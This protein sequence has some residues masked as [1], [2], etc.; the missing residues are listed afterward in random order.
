MSLVLKYI[1]FWL[2]ILLSI[3]FYRL[4]LDNHFYEVLSNILLAF[5]FIFTSHFFLNKILSVVVWIISVVVFNVCVFIQ[6]AHY[7][8]FQDNIKSS[9]LFIVFDTDSSEANDF[10]SMYAD[11]SLVVTA[12]ILLITI[13]I[14]IA[15]VYQELKSTKNTPKRY[16]IFNLK[17]NFRF[18]YL[19][20]ILIIGLVLVN[21]IRAASLP[22]TAFK[23]YNKYT[24]ENKK[25]NDVAVNKLGGKFTNVTHKSSNNSEV[26]VLI[27]GEST[28]RNHMQLYG[29]NRKTTPKLNSIKNSLLV[30]N[31]VITPHTHTIKSLEKVLTLAN[32]RNPE[33]KFDGS[34]IQLFNK[35]GFNTYW[36]SNQTPLGINETAT[37]VL[38]K[39]CTERYFLNTTV[40]E[41][42]YDEKVLKP[43]DLVLSKKSEKK[44][45]VI[46]LLGTHGNYINR[47]PSIYSTFNGKPE[48]NFKHDKAFA[49]I[50][51]YDNAVLYNDF[52]VT[53]IIKKV[54]NRNSKSFA[55]YFSDHGEDVYN[56]MDMACHT[57]SKGSK[58]M[59]D[60][61]FILWQSEIYKKENTDL[62][63]NVN[64][65]WSTEDL[66][67][68]LSDLA[69]IKFNQFDASRSL[70]NSKFEQKE[71]L[72]FNN[73]TYNETF[74]IQ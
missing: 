68:T 33:K 32:S 51:A 53:E 46:H 74:K 10:F 57:E 18:N 66:I 50:N 56:T 38:S 58:P 31:N 27:I 15:V 65:P 28:T 12:V 40:D 20:F 59:Y 16:S 21:N 73:K 8:L 19:L 41:K 26:Y 48:T 60:I 2:P 1:G 43:L 47:Y 64:R 13:I 34:I 6:I 39:S 24:I 3:F 25:Y 35:A 45:I 62:V 44:L 36:I 63:F 14:N 7:Y 61:P 30:F 37:T 4:D 67:F 11:A 42:S 49:T 69:Q 54:K 71:R 17:Y 5:V 29:Y 22:Y 55:L 23:A 9:T 70:I 52:I 72:I